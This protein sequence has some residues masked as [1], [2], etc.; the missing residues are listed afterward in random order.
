MLG[1]LTIITCKKTGHPNLHNIRAGFMIYPIDGWLG[2]IPNDWVID[3]DFED[4]MNGITEY[5]CPYAARN[6]TPF[7]ACTSIK[8]FSCEIE[9]KNVTL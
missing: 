6:I 5:K 3:P 2:C 1:K 8:G 4:P 9:D 7:E